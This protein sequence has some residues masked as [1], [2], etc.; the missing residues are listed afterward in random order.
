MKKTR[1]LFIETARQV[2]VK[3]GVAR[4]TMNDIA[5]ASNRGRRTLYTYFKSKEDVYYAV[6][7]Q[8]L[9]HLVEC[10]EKIIDKKIP[11]NEKLVEYIYIHLDSI[12]DIVQSNGTLRADF[13]NDIKTVER[14][15]RQTSIKEL[16]MLKIILREGVNSGLFGIK[17]IDTAAA[18]ILY[19]LKGLEVP[20]IKENVAERMAE[21]KEAIAAFIFKGLR[22]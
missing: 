6:V 17:D 5:E 1:Q 10:L 14:I 16:K 11:A 21:R 8:E 12:R 7:E 13:F 15:R 2:F 9:A 4:A 22:P 18:I 3:M 19:S 20:Y